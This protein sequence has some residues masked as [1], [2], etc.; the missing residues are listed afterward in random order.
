MDREVAEANSDLS[1]I[2]KKK[3]SIWMQK[4]DII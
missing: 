3:E 2:L 4:E 1:L